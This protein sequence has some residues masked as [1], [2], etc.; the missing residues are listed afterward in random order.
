[1]V[2]LGWFLILLGV[3][4]LVSGIAVILKSDNM[5]I[6]NALVAN[7]RSKGN[8]DEGAVRNCTE[9]E[10]KGRLFEEYIVGLLPKNSSVKLEE[11]QGDKCSNGVYPMA[12]R[13]PDLLLTIKLKGGGIAHVAIEC[14]WRK[15]F[16]NNT[17]EWTT[18]EKIEIYKQYGVEHNASVF[19][20]LGVG[21]SPS[22]PQ[23]LF[24]VPLSHMSEPVIV[25]SN[26]I[27]FKSENTQGRL[28][29]KDYTNALTVLP[30]NNN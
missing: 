30:T 4:L 17:L 21:G 23:E 5:P 14:K 18:K 19:V 8:A 10:I 13:N 16:I 7:S 12:N 11:W 20:A 6:Y 29:Y 28:F 22:N 25:Y 9:E 26:I 24:F 27:G 2:V 15:S 3:I 1:M